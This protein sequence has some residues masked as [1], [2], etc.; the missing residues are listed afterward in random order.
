MASGGSHGAAS[1]GTAHVGAPAGEPVDLEK[2]EAYYVQ[3]YLLIVK[4]VTALL[5]ARFDLA[6]PP[7]DLHK[8]LQNSIKIL[9]YAKNKNFINKTQWRLLF[10]QNQAPSSDTFD[11][12]L[13]VYLLRN[14]CGLKSKWWNETDNSKIPD[15]VV[16]EEA[17][18]ARLRNLRNDVIILLLLDMI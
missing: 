17:D 18:I 11:V 6:V 12:T 8:T 5:R 16:T 13:L 4:E 3:M 2:K 10:P 9:N 7:H 15:F 1:G 14:I